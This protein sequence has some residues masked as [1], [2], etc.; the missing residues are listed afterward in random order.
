ML[1][2]AGDARWLAGMQLAILAAY[3]PI[4]LLVRSHASDVAT[5]WWAFTAWMLLRGVALGWRARGDA[6]LVTGATR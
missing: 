1:I 4:A 2:G 5:L 3:V 6:W